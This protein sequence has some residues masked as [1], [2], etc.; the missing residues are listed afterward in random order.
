[1]PP[2]NAEDA[3]P[4]GSSPHRLLVNQPPLSDDK[5]RTVNVL[6]EIRPR[7]EY[8]TDERSLEMLNAVLSSRQ[9]RRKPRWSRVAAVGLC[10]V[11]ITG[12]AAYATGLVPHI[13]TDRFQ[14]IRGGQD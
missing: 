8:L 1:M 10:G 7:A 2:R 3:T 6:D 9:R 13:V 11:I 12:G 14:Q 5:E 4:P